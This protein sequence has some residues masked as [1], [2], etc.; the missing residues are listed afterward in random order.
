MAESPAALA[1]EP[2]SSPSFVLSQTTVAGAGATSTSVS[3]VLDGTL[4]QAA[5]V[6]DSTSP[7]F[8]LESGF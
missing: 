5:T 7:T 8:K 4:S 6:G 3:F 1:A 2:A